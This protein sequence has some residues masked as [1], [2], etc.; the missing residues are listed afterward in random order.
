MTE[1]RIICSPLFCLIISLSNTLVILL[2]VDFVMVND[3]RIDIE[4]NGR[5]YWRTMD[6][7]DKH[8]DG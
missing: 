4:E 5:M 2:R 3:E 1:E 8:L 6:F 7:E